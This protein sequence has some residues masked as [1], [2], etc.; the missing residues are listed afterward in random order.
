MND[1]LE[2]RASVLNKPRRKL[3]MCHHM[4]GIMLGEII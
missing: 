1:V 4:A 3:Y 2:Y